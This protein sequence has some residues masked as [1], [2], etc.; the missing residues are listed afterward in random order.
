MF[1]I[2]ARKILLPSDDCKCSRRP[3]KWQDVKSS[4]KFTAKSSFSNA[5]SL[6]YSNADLPTKKKEQHMPKIRSMLRVKLLPNG[7]VAGCLP[8][9]IAYFHRPRPLHWCRRPNTVDYD[10]AQWNHH[11]D[12]ATESMSKMFEKDSPFRSSS[13]VQATAVFFS[14]SLDLSR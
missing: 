4:A 11:S 10:R 6:K 14:S 2:W 12:P 8:L 9:T 1:K 13:C 3:S 7:L 5:R